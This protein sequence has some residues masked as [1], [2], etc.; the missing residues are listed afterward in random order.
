MNKNVKYILIL[1][2][3]CYFY[4]FFGNNLF[5]LTSPD[6]VFYVQTAKEM[7]ANNTWMTPILFDSPQFEKPVFIYWLLRSAFLIFG[8][9]SFSV[10]FFPALF[11]F[12]GIITVY[13]FAKLLFKE[14]KKAFLSSLV[15]LSSC[16]Y[17]G[18][19]RTV[20]TDM[21]FS[22]FILLSLFSF[23]C[24]YLDQRRKG[25]G[26]L[27]FFIFSALAV[28]TKG[29]LGLIIPLAIIVV[30]LI[31]ARRIKFIF[32]KYTLWGLV[33]FSAIALPWYILMTVKYGNGFIHE[34]F[35]ND[36]YRRLIVAEHRRHDT[37]YFYPL[38]TLGCMFPWSFFVIT[39]L[40]YFFR[41][42]NLTNTSNL[43][44]ACWIVVTFF[45]FQIARSK[46]TSYI[47]P[48]FGGLAIISG[49][50]IYDMIIDKARRK[51]FFAISGALWFIFLLILI[52]TIAAL[53]KFSYYLSSL[54]PAYLLV[55]IFM[56][57]L[58]IAIFN[59]INKRAL[60]IFYM[61]V[62]FLP[63]FMSIIP[64]IYKDA[65]PYFSS[66][67]ACDYLLK[68]YSLDKNAYLLCSKDF[69]RGTRFYTDMKIAVFAPDGGNYFSPHPIP[70]LDASAK[71][72]EFLRQQ[73]VTYGFL[74]ES[75]LDDLKGVMGEDLELQVL[76][77]IGN[78]YIIKIQSK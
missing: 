5:S 38:T 46:L 74:K 53:F 59:F 45:I 73:P 4:F 7:L 75:S 23:Y 32:C 44:L 72:E 66:K 8:I 19:A 63:V 35:Y 22:V 12:I 31:L 77:K 1:T 27:F 49:G 33:I 29:P 71:T 70:V 56:L 25:L 36:H 60:A 15:L 76:N 42:K 47:F 10:R 62:L 50:F 14:E 52:C 67:Y 64:F 34:F 39:A 28:L 6:E 30:F 54:W 40:F 37:W 21:V 2:V 26:I 11:G 24:G 17:I 68:N 9:N 43:F 58:V 55:F 13:F 78:E 41:S 65:E 57:W 16:L 20:F 3:L 51:Q 61:F 18:L 69:A 48:L